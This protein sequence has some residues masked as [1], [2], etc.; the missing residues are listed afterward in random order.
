MNSTM[1]DV[2]RQASSPHATLLVH[3]DDAAAASRTATG[4]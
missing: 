3:P 1:R 2:G 4:W